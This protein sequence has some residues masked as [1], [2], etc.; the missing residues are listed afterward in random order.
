M[1]NVYTQEYIGDTS[2]EDWLKLRKSG[3]G[4]SDASVLL[5]VNP[6]TS[7]MQLYKDKTSQDIKTFQNEAMH[8]GHILEE[9]VAQEFAVRTGLEVE[10]YPYFMRSIQHPFITANIDRKIKTDDGSFVGLECKTTSA[11]QEFEWGDNTIPIYYYIQVQHYMYVTGAKE[12]YVAVL[13]GGNKFRE[14]HVDRDEEMIK[15]IVEQEVKFWNNHV[16]PRKPPVDW[17]FVLGNNDSI[18]KMIDEYAKLYKNIGVLRKRMQKLERQIQSYMAQH[19]QNIISN[20]KY[21]ATV[22]NGRVMLH[23]ISEDECVNE[24]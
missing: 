15:T 7:V 8:F 2:L 12:W 13:I 4:G 5:G 17:K 6:W 18:H 23:P 1:A 20:G 24:L 11:S 9:I 10:V 14:Y 21:T 19:E 3:I 16:V 22:E